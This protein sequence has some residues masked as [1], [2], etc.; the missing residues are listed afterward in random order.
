MSR[1]SDALEARTKATP[2]PWES[3]SFGD[4][5][6]KRNETL[7]LNHIADIRGWAWLS[8]KYG[9]EKAVELQK[10]NQFI[11]AAAPDA[12]E[13]ISEA[14]PWLMWIVA[15]AN[16]DAYLSKDDIEAVRKLI[17]QA[18]GGNNDCSQTEGWE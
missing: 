2:G 13:W 6:W 18:E 14:L 7:E 15:N 1:L 9:E 5:V 10:A 16:Y 3:D 8:K 17:A 12:L 11:I 4:Q